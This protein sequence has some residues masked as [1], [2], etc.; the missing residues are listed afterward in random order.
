VNAW[1]FTSKAN[2]PVS[3]KMNEAATTSGKNGL[4]FLLVLELETPAGTLMFQD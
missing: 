2:E 3:N 4:L 1:D